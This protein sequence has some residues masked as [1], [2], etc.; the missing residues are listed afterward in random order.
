MFVL[1][2]ATGYCRE[3]E[4]QQTVCT[5][6][7]WAQRRAIGWYWYCSGVH[8]LLTPSRP[9]HGT[10]KLVYALAFSARALSRRI[11]SDASLILALI[12]SSIPS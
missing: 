4:C 7:G 3:I 1:M 10:V 9:K 12:L 2:N 6:M 5:G 8:L 11:S